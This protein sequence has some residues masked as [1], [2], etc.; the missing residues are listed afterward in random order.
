MRAVLL[1][2]SILVGIITG[3]PSSFAITQYTE[4]ILILSGST[5]T[6]N[7]SYLHD[8]YNLKFFE[9]PN[10]EHQLGLGIIHLSH[11]QDID[12]TLRFI[13][14]ETLEKSFLLFQLYLNED[15]RRIAEQTTDDYSSHDVT[16]LSYNHLIKSGTMLVAGFVQ[17]KEMLIR[18]Q[19]NNTVVLGIYQQLTP[20]TILA[21]GAGPDI[22]GGL[23]NFRVTAGLQ[24]SF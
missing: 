23:S 8:P 24:F 14:T 2:T 12:T 17:S 4:Y 18:S 1:F 11:Y 9:P 3:G 19:T 10:E 6:A 15:W 16:I 7:T 20:R 13:I 5:E 22:R 21:I